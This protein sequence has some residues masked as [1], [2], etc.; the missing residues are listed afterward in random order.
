[1]IENNFNVAILKEP[2]RGGQAYVAVC[3]EHYI[4]AQGETEA[5]ALEALEMTMWWQAY[6]DKKEG[7]VPFQAIAPA[8]DECKKRALKV[9]P[10]SVDYD[11]DLG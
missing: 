6:L 5:A 3:L 8:P 11:K 9:V 7:R 2:I 10:F 4:A 1:M